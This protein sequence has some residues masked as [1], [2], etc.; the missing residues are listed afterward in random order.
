MQEKNNEIDLI[1]LF[2]KIIRAI[3]D[4]TVAFIVAF[5]LGTALGLAYYQY[6]PNVYESKMILLSDILTS[7]YSER[8]TETLNGLIREKNH[9]LLSDRLGLS[10]TD[11]A[12]ISKIEIESIRQE[13]KKDE[14]NESA[15][16][17]VT[18][19]VLNKDIFPK[20]QEGMINYLSNNEFV[21]I[22]V[23]QRQNYYR[24][25]IE[26]VQNEISSLDSLKRRLFLGQPVY[27]K[28]AEML[29]VDP[30]SIYSKVIELNK[31]LVTDKNALEIINSIQLVEGFTVLQKPA[32]PRL[33]Y[34]LAAGVSMGVF[35]VCIM[36]VFKSVRKLLRF[37][38]SQLEKH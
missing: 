23:L 22:R 30:T 34:S 28:T 29:L 21:K 20:L 15:T 2:A 13:A 24:T 10:L 12:S 35:F 25:M 16:F 37:S 4:N 6:S 18:A 26:K 3:R 14:K 19:S 7:S 1:E 9:K 8:L 38:E 5:V 32:S 27:S 31:E 36:I 17:I 11:A 33:S